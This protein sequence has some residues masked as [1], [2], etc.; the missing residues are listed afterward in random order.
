MDKHHA[1]L[2]CY[3][4][5]FTC[6]VGEGSHR[7]VQGVP[8]PIVVREISALQLKKSFRKGCQVVAVHMKEEAKEQ[9][10]NELQVQ[11]EE[12]LKRGTYAQVFHLGGASVFSGKKKDGTLSCALISDSGIRWQRR[13]S[14]LCQ[15]WMISLIN[16]KESRVSL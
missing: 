1:V 13:T 11:L 14:V 2:D 4:K 16:W 9:E 10:L 3:N 15:G 8:R 5:T 7:T 12:L 6:L